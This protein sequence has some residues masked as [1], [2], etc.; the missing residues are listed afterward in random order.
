MRKFFS[1]LKRRKVYRVAVAYAVGAWLIAQVVTQ[2]FPVFEVSQWAMRTMIVLLIIGFPFALILSWAFDITPQG[3]KRTED[4][5][6]TPARARLAE[7]IP[8]KSIAV[9]P[10]ENL[11]DDQQNT[12]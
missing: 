5:D 12:Y 7:P 4:V 2:I 11:S 6:V 8:E 10:F 9:L 1:E 3:I